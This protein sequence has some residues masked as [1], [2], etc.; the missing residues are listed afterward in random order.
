VLGRIVFH[1][2]N[3]I[4][5]DSS[6]SELGVVVAALPRAQAAVERMFSSATWQSPERW[7]LLSDTL[8]TEV[9]KNNLDEGWTIL[10]P[11]DFYLPQCAAAPFHALSKQGRDPRSFSDVLCWFLCCTHCIPSHTHM[12]WRNHLIAS[13]FFC[14]HERECRNFQCE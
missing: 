2:W 6:I 9:K 7:S 5:S 14:S 1:Y 10:F 4:M 13:L 8:P 3:L 12:L 11:P